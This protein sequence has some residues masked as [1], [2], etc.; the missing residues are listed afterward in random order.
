MKTTFFKI[1]FAFALILSVGVFYSCSGDTSGTNSETEH[2][3]EHHHDSEA[4][5]H[6]GHSHEHEGADASESK[7]ICPMEC[8]GSAKEEPGSC[9]VCGMDL[10]LRSEL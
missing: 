9:P 1:F 5:D 3:D 8:E 10:V 6:E 2:V 4:H 7:Y